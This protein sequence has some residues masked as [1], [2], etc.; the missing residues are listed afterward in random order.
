MRR[1][2]KDH[3]GTDN[4]SLPAVPELDLVLYHWSP[5]QNRAN[6]LKQGLSPGRSSLQGDWKPPYVCFSDEPDLAWRLSG[7]M[8]GEIKEWDLWMCNVTFQ[9]S[10]AHYEIITD[11]YINTGRHYVKEYR[12]YTRVYKRDLV[13]VGSRSN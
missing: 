11:T 12:I 2:R 7:A 4:S 1:T 3:S 13:Y 6:I 5:R 9:T 8:W 10:F